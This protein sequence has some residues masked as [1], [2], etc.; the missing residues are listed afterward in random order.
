M[1]L[2]NSGNDGVDH[3]D[4][5]GDLVFPVLFGVAEEDVRRAVLETLTEND[6]WTTYGSR[7]VS[8]HEKNYSPDFGYQLVGGLWPNLTAWVAYCLRN[9]NPELLAEGMRNIYRLSEESIPKNFGHVV[10]GEFPERLH[11]ETFRSQGMPLSPWMPPTYLWLGVEGLL[12]VDPRLDALTVEPH[13]PV[14]WNWIAVKDLQYR[15]ESVSLFVYDGI[16][17]CTHPV[18]SS[19]PIKVG[20]RIT[21]GHD[22]LFCIGIEVDGT[23]CIFAASEEGW[24]GTITIHRNAH[25]ELVEVSVGKSTAMLYRVNGHSIVESKAK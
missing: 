2:L 7:T 25:Q 23:A 3:H 15:G 12:G 17:Y 5:T 4:L 11:G 13:L 9:E 18:K 8:K 6:L 19:L 21:I 22:D 14:S 10:P 1:Y 24:K 16:L 20:R